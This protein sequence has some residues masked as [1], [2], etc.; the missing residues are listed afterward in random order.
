MV[1]RSSELE[2]EGD[3]VC[4]LWHIGIAD[5]RFLYCFEYRRHLYAKIDAG[6]CASQKRGGGSANAAQHVDLSDI[7]TNQVAVA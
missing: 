6:G 7:P 5:I 2:R 4:V 1:R 3:I